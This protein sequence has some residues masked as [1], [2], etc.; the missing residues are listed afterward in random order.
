VTIRYDNEPSTQGLRL[1]PAV[2]RTLHAQ[3]LVD[4]VMQS[5]DLPS[6]GEVIIGRSRDAQIRVDHASISR[7]HAAIV[8][9]KS[10][11]LQDLGSSNGT[12]VGGRRLAPGE[13]LEIGTD[14]VIDLGAISL[15]IRGELTAVEGESAM[16]ALGRLVDRIA[17][18]E[19][20]VLILGETGVGKELMA[21]TIHRRSLRASG[22][23]LRIN[24][25]AL[26]ETLV[27]S[28]LFGHL[29]GA[30][31]GAD[32]AKPGLLRAAHG[33]TV[34][35]DEI[36]ELPPR[37]QVKLL[38]VLESGE[39]LPVGGV[40]PAKIDVRFIAAT[41]RD[42]TVE[43]AADRFRRD[44]YFRLNGIS[45]TIPPL[46]ERLD[47]LAALAEELARQAQRRSGKVGSVTFTD[48]ALRHLR[49][50]SWP[51]NI[52]ELKNVV[53]RAVLLC[54]GQPIRPEHFGAATVEPGPAMPSDPE[55]QRILEALDACA[56]NQK[57]AAQMLGMARNT[58]AAR[59]DA[60]HIPRPR[61]AH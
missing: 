30:F 44:L 34:F 7:Q 5:F 54:E 60:L 33:G 1:D 22:P 14:Q 29:K 32:S 16:K 58:L 25:G 20:S 59:L 18:G 8:V 35:L 48:A 39:V 2:A 3:V 19:L 42:L 12:R 45:F 31:T 52:R 28:E 11:H 43:M 36:G 55:R 21:E 50:Q 10:L 40:T 49:R 61:K 47:E 15:V 53:E 4:G 37:Q 27:D 6:S 24:C 46:R 57:K 38:R 56:G 9:G 17:P 26:S 13:S 41:N 23:M 51:G